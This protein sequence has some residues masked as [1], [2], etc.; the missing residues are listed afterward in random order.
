MRENTPAC[1]A[2]LSGVVKLKEING[3]V[4]T[5]IRKGII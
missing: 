2:N 4:N 1:R 5:K 3:G